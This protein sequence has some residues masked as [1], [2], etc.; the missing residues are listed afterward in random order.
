MTL[1]VIDDFYKDP[2]SVRDLAL[3]QE[4]NIRGDFPAVRGG[5][6]FPY[7]LADRIQ[8]IV[9]PFA[10]EIIRYVGHSGVFQLCTALDATKV[11]SDFMEEYPE[12]L[13]AAV[14][15]LTPDAPLSAGTGFFKC[16]H[17]GKQTD[18]APHPN[19]ATNY[20]MQNCHDQTKFEQVSVV[21]N[22][23]NRAIFYKGNYLHRAMNYFGFKKEDA[24]L[25]QTFFFHVK[26]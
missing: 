14:I 19:E 25:T 22:I 13:W 9:K 24:R 26:K 8:E 23:Y 21:G 10:G 1:I 16:K 11:H 7:E 5:Y 2:D 18:D 15:Y 6:Y 17:T 20:H 3:S 4:F 12:Q